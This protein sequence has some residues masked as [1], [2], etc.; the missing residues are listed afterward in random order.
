MWGTR[1][2]LRHSVEAAWSL[3]TKLSCLTL[4]TLPA[5]LDPAGGRD[6][7]PAAE[8]GVSPLIGAHFSQGHPETCAWC[9]ERSL[10]CDEELPGG[11]GDGPALS[12][13]PRQRRGSQPAGAKPWPH[14]VPRHSGCLGSKASCSRW[15]WAENVVFVPSLCAPVLIFLMFIVKN[16]AKYS[17]I[18]SVF[19]LVLV[20]RGDRK[21]YFICTFLV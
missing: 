7:T 16:V 20:Q 19:H 12:A 18:G 3:D 5:G 21:Y 10:R 14:T 1:C 6:R 9:E 4:W 2:Q 13:A 11:A 17:L 8:K 15:A